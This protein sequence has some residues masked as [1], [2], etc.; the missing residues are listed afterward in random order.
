MTLQDWTNNLE[1]AENPSSFGRVISR[2]IRRQHP[3][4]DLRKSGSDNKAI[5]DYVS[6]RLNVLWSDVK[7]WKMLKEVPEES[8]IQ[9]YIEKHHKLCLP[10]FDHAVWRAMVA[11][12]AL[13]RRLFELLRA[14]AKTFTKARLTT[15]AQNALDEL[16]SRGAERLLI[17]YIQSPSASRRG[18]LR[19]F[20]LS[21]STLRELA[22][23]AKRLRKDVAWCLENKNDAKPEP[24][25]FAGSGQQKSAE[26]VKELED[27]VRVV[28]PHR[29][30]TDE[31]NARRYLIDRVKRDP[32]QID[33]KAVKKYAGTARVA[34]ELV[35]FRERLPVKH[36]VDHDK[37]RGLRPRRR[38]I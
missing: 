29:F 23:A 17:Q 37:K 5:R 32:S 30:D 20:K 15:G 22:E 25:F 38:N 6:H 3:G 19:W 21:D 1:A 27:M 31:S 4:A 18:L 2:R 7:F 8:E 13:R 35:E 9:D 36:H 26:A 11:N 12:R 33:D 10:P 16:K 28:R 24:S 14:R 34:K